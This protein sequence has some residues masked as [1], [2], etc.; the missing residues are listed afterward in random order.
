ML[1]L[2]HFGRSTAAQT[3]RFAFAEKWREWE[4]HYTETGPDKH[5]Q[6]DK[7]WSVATRPYM[8]QDGKTNFPTAPV[9][10]HE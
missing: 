9:K 8:G 4:R 1:E 5:D 2:Y 3:V 7:N 6:H 10:C